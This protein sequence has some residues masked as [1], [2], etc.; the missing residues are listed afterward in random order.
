MKTRFTKKLLAYLIIAL[1]VI[2]SI[3]GIS[4]L[5]LYYLQNKTQYPEALANL[6]NF[7]VGGISQ[8]FRQ[9]QT[10]SD[11]KSSTRSTQK[12]CVMMKPV[13][14]SQMASLESYSSG[15]HALL[16]LGFQLRS[17]FQNCSKGTL[18]MWRSSI[19]VSPVLALIKSC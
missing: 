6:T 16:G 17:I 3:E 14:L 1:V 2:L 15:I 8:T 12:D 11:L 4:R 13:M 19:W 9:R 10:R 18:G 5:F 7:L